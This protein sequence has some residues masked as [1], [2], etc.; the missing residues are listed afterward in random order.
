MMDLLALI[1][2]LALCAVVVAILS[3][4]PTAWIREEWDRIRA[5]TW[6]ESAEAPKSDANTMDD[7]RV[8]RTFLKLREARAGMKRR[9]TKLLIEG[10]PGWQRINPMADTPAPRRVIS[11]KTAKK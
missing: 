9:G 6:A 3:G 7:P 10:R 8:Q 11:I 2:L 4:N 5:D 1:V